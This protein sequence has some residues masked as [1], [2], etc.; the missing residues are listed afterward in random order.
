M[1]TVTSQS[2]INH[3]VYLTQLPFPVTYLQKIAYFRFKLSKFIEVEVKQQAYVTQQFSISHRCAESV[4]TA[5]SL[6]LRLREKVV[7][8][9]RNSC[10]SFAQSAEERAKTG[11]SSIIPA[12]PVTRALGRDACCPPLEHGGKCLL[13]L[14]IDSFNIFE[15]NES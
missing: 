15:I 8:C 6:E 12:V 5:H 10:V 2:I 13:K 1:L 14:R 3:K 11:F 7:R 4:S 9:L